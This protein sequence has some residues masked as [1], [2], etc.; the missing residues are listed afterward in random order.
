MVYDI[1][2]HGFLNGSSSI[3]FLGL[4]FQKLFGRAAA[5]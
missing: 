3:N 1:K 4:F 5:E 2:T